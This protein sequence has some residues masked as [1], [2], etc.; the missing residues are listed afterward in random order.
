MVIQKA[1]DGIQGDLQSLVLGKTVV[2]G[3]NQGKRNGFTA[4]FQSQ[5]K[6][7]FIAAAQQPGFPKQPAPPHRANRMDDILRIQAKAGGDGGFPHADSADALP[8]GQKLRPRRPVNKRIPPAAN[9]RPGVGCVHDGIHP[10][11]GYVVSNN[12]KGHIPTC[13]SFVRV[14]R[15]SSKCPGSV[16][17]FTTKV[18]VWGASCSLTKA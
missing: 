5:R 6:G 16:S 10:H 4:I 18:I 1:P 2:P 12:L 13:S 15:T 17:M 8:R 3:G 9:H 7:G 14:S 11:F